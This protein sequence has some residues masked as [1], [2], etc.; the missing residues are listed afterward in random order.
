MD[1]YQTI[2]QELK[3]L[4]A[5]L[6]TERQALAN[7]ATQYDALCI[8]A[9]TEAVSSEEVSALRSQKE[10]LEAKIHGL[11]IL[12]GQK[13]AEKAAFEQVVSARLQREHE[14]ADRAE[15]IKRWR[16]LHA[17]CSA[18]KKEMEATVIPLKEAQDDIDEQ[19]GVIQY[20]RNELSNHIAAKPRPSDF[21]TEQEIAAWSAR[22]QAL[23][24]AVAES[25]AEMRRLDDIRTCVLQRQVQARSD[26]ERLAFQERMARLPGFDQLAAV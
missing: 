12:L 16:A 9:C 13:E 18:A 1:A 11:Q 19:A 17:E 22:L 26:F 14:E 20:A 25:F 2:N 4:R 21:A 23:E 6:E 5:N 15:K 3:S 8:L 10:F 7:L 24:A